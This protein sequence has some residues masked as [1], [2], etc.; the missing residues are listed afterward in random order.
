MR[1]GKVSRHSGRRLHKV[2]ARLQIEANESGAVCLGMV[3]DHFGKY[4]S[5]E[6]L[7]ERCGVGRDGSTLADL[8]EG[9]RY[10]NLEP[11]LT[12]G[13]PEDLERLPG[14]AILLWRNYQFVVLEGRRRQ[15]WRVNDP[16]RGKRRIDDATFRTDFS[17]DYLSLAEGNDFQRGGRKPSPLA[18]LWRGA[19]SAMT[20]LLILT[21]LSLII[22]VPTLAVPWLLRDFV[23]IFLVGGHESVLV[24]L[25]L[26]LVTMTVLQIGTILLQQHL[27]A[28]VQTTIIVKMSLSVMQRMLT[29]PFRFFQTR[30]VAD[31]AVRTESVAPIANALGGPMAQAFMGVL[32]AVVATT[33]IFILNFW[34][35]VVS[36]ATAVTFGA[37]QWRWLKSRRA[38]AQR[39]ERE[40]IDVMMVA[41]GAVDLF[42]T[43]KTIGDNRGI[44]DQ[45]SD[46]LAAVQTTRA[47]N[48][49]KSLLGLAA[50]GLMNGI[51]QTLI[52]MVGATA[53]IN[54]TMTIGTMIAVQVLAYLQLGPVSQLLMTADQV[55]LVEASLKRIDDVEHQGTERIGSSHQPTTPEGLTGSVEVHEVA[56]GYRPLA[57]P[58]IS[59]FSLQVLPGRRVA[60]VGG[61]G[62]GKS[63]LGRLISGISKPW[64]G[65]VEFDGVSLELIPTAIATTCIAYVEQDVVL[66]AGSIRDNITMWD[67]RIPDEDVYRALRDSQVA[68][69]VLGRPGGLDWRVSDRGVGFSGGQLQRIGIARALAKNPRVLILDEATSAMDAATEASVDRAIQQRG[70][71]TIVIAH[72]LSTIRDADEII[73][74]EEGEVMERGTHEVLLAQSGAYARLVR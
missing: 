18:A 34:L 72:R 2:P 54:G 10:F 28:R 24:P 60:I 37:W 50:P 6:E 21:L 53:V 48:D 5:P 1:S 41:G 63:T 67:P 40:L 17:G 31:L 13:A 36:L 66:F 33:M 14:P 26:G 35:G 25:L 62:S 43:V 9:A 57:P 51:G 46:R 55:L 7:R 38:A 52:L 19:S 70:C 47:Y 59:D 68:D 71:T 16:A 12:A 27:F 73:V 23:D 3:L 20:G 29:A 58:L 61:S 30:A 32:T 44:T 8:A 39:E 64:A 15:F 42:E 4:V 65:T 45:F 49:R 11:Q 74:L 69:E 22:V 56:F